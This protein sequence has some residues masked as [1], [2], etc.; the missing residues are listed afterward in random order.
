MKNRLLKCTFWMKGY[1]VKNLPKI[2][3]NLIRF[4][5]LETLIGSQIKEFSEL[6]LYFG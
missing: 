2:D 1:A 6:K 5:P 3:L 4:Y